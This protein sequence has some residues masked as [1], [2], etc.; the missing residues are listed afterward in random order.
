MSRN[1]RIRRKVST[2]QRE[3]KRGVMKKKANGKRNGEPPLSQFADLEGKR[4]GEKKEKNE[5][6]DKAPAVREKKKTN[7]GEW[8]LIGTNLFFLKKKWTKREKNGDRVNPS[9]RQKKMV[10]G[11]EKG[12]QRAVPKGGGGLS[13]KKGHCLLG[14][15]G[16]N[17]VCTFRGKGGVFQRGPKGGNHYTEYTLELLLP[18]N[19]HGANQGKTRDG[20]S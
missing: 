12:G 17:F 20:N 19:L 4:K 16:K 8:I 3:K 14:G 10:G 9:A 2:K 15:G 1:P 6:G 11:E 18:G 5:N 7:E 13:G